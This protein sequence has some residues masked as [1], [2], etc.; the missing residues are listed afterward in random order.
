V[1]ARTVDNDTSFVEHYFNQEFQRATKTYEEWVRGCKYF[2]GQL[3]NGRSLELELSVK[4]KTHPEFKE[5]MGTNPP[6]LHAIFKQLNTLV[7]GEV[8]LNKFTAKRNFEKSLLPKPREKLQQY[9][10][11]VDSDL[12]AL[13]TTHGVIIDE[14]DLVNRILYDGLSCYPHIQDLLVP[15]RSG[16]EEIPSEYSKLKLMV[17]NHDMI[18]DPDSRFLPATQSVAE[19]ARNYEPRTATAAS[20]AESAPT[21]YQGQTSTAKYSLSSSSSITMTC[22][23][24]G[25]K[26]HLASTCQQRYAQEGKSAVPKAS[27][28]L[29]PRDGAKPRHQKHGG[30]FKPRGDRSSVSLVEASDS[31]IEHPLCRLMMMKQM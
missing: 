25:K 15:W 2:A 7:Q 21:S 24:C 4:L 11:R 17:L 9:I 31:G 6:D 30:R 26:G 16:K 5:W 22:Q 10:L 1:K 8:K 12:Q 19:K 29:N 23:I 13:I 14:E 20:V 28:A 3:F 18:R 27:K